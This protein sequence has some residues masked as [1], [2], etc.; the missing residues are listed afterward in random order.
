MKKYKLLFVIFLIVLVSVFSPLCIYL[1]VTLGVLS[2]FT[3]VFNQ[4]LNKEGIFILLFS[5]SYAL[6][7]ILKGEVGSV[8]ITASYIICP[9]AFY[10]LGQTLTTRIGSQK[11]FLTM[12][13]L[14]IICYILPLAIKTINSISAF[15]IVN[16]F[17]TMGSEGEGTLSATLFGLHS[18]I[19]I[20]A[21]SILFC[22][23]KEIKWQKIALNICFLLS[24]LTIIHLINRTGLI[25][26]AC[27]VIVC[28]IY[29]VRNNPKKIIMFSLLLGVIFFAVEHLG[30]ISKDI[31]K[32]YEAREEFSSYNA[33]SIGGRTELWGNALKLIFTDPLG[34]T[35]ERYAHNL[36]L[37][38]ARISGIIPLIF[39]LIASFKNYLGV[40]R[41]MI[42]GDSLVP[43]MLGLNVA[44][45]LSAFVEP[46]IEGSFLY[47]YIL[48]FLWGCNR[49]LLYKQFR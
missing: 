39:F 5:I 48:M 9:L 14:I 37:D 29:K 4:H 21:I 28:I 3:T 11:Q 19:G 38:I 33:N 41:Y 30:L 13:S 44:T 45:F 15:G 49:R 16:V 23:I 22:T 42:R 36:W 40:Y 26:L 24:L 31:V 35:N 7:I 27:V 20:A 8:A 43:F 1:T 18:S 34:F 12:W 10:S 47:F 2:L 32:A 25:V 46:V 6:M 17:R